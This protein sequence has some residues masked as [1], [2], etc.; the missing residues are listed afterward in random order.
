MK[1]DIDQ[2]LEDVFYEFDLFC[3]KEG[4]IYRIVSDEASIQ[5]YLTK[6]NKGQPKL[7][8][9]MDKVAKDH[10][11]HMEVDDKRKGGVLYTFTLGSLSEMGSWKLLPKKRKSEDYSPFANID[12]ARRVRQEKTMCQ[13]NFNERLNDALVEADEYVPKEKGLIDRNKHIIIHKLAQQ[14]MQQDSGMTA[15]EAKL[16][17]IEM[18]NNGIRDLFEDQYKHP[19]K[20]HTLKQSTYRSSFGPSRSFGGVSTA[21]LGMGHMQQE[22]I[23]PRLD[24][25]GNPGMVSAQRTTVAGGKKDDYKTRPYTKRRD[26]NDLPKTVKKKDFLGELG[27]AVERATRGTRLGRCQDKKI[28]QVDPKQMVP[29]PNHESNNPAEDLPFEAQQHW[30]TFAGSFSQA[31]KGPSRSSTNQRTNF[32][33]TEEQA[34]DTNEN[35]TDGEAMKI[36]THPAEAEPGYIYQVIAP[37]GTK[38]AYTNKSR[39]ID[40]LAEHPGSTANYVQGEMTQSNDSDPMDDIAGQQNMRPLGEFGPVKQTAPKG[41]TVS[42]VRVQHPPTRSFDASFPRISVQGSPV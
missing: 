41:N 27:L 14:L 19:N 21:S 2:A 40:Y 31:I 5:G 12:D 33:E 17:A 34:Q 24:M 23:M 15:V 42:N 16:M 4:I 8:N 7:K 22:M 13:K 37:D 6:G 20:R 29:D 38:M 18:Y 26:A 30:P 32:G 39:A 36:S 9:Y 11:V 1:E 10:S 3:K 28:R 25:S 35:G